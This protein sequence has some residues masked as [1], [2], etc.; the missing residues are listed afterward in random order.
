MNA[1]VRPA[2]YDDL[3]RLPDHV[4]GEILR[5]QLHSQPRPSSRHA[6]IETGLAS[7]LFGPFDLGGGGP[8][9]WIILT[10][11]ELHL[12]ANV[13]VPDLAGWR[14]ERLSSI[15]DG[16]ITVVPDWVCEILSPSTAMKDRAVKLPLYGELGVKHAW[17][18]DPAA[19]T[20]EVLRRDDEHWVLLATHGQ[21]DAMR[22][23]PFAAVAL[24]LGGLWPW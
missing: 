3:L 1:V 18:V 2:Q 22:A 5:G 14:R 24:E 16:P 15:P 11:P 17:I 12:G 13:I 19:K 20:I 4:T 7:G 21:Q 6:R 10:E 8:G 23:E 9:G